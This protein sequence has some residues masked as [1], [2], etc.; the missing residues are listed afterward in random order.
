V[1]FRLQ[2][3]A[4]WRRFNTH[5]PGGRASGLLEIAVTA[6]L[7]PADS[8]HLTYLSRVGALPIQPY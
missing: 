5:R 8:S 4:K 3:S 7:R 6:M 1:S 2:L